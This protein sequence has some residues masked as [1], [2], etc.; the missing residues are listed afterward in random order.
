M[1][2]KAQLQCPGEVLQILPA[3]VRL[4]GVRQGQRLF[5]ATEP[6]RQ[7]GDQRLQHRVTAG[8]LLAVLLGQ[9]CKQCVQIGAFSTD[10]I[11]GRSGQH[12]T[13]EQAAQLLGQRLR[14][15]EYVAL[16]VFGELEGVHTQRRND[17]QSRRIDVI[18]HLLHFQA[19]LPGLHVQKLHQIT[20]SMG[21]YF[22]AVK[23]A[24]RRYRLAVNQ[25]GRR[26]GAGFAIQFEHRDR[27]R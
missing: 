17:L 16:N 23:L 26:P 27:Y 14:Q 5:A 2:A 8:L 15:T 9:G 13:V 7:H 1:L 24:A 19:R 20:V 3:P 4:R 22:P 11:T 18:D 6:D 10:R 21:L 25:V 12:R